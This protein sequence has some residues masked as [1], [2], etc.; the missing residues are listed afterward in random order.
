MQITFFIKIRFRIKDLRVRYYKDYIN[1]NK[2]E[3]I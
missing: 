2:I 1:K 3:Y